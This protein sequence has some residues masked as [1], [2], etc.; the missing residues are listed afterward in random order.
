M[1]KAKTSGST[2]NFVHRVPKN[3]K[4]QSAKKHS[5]NKASKKYK[6]PYRGQ[7]R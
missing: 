1:A 3:R 2:I 6:K 7:G 5:K 4:G